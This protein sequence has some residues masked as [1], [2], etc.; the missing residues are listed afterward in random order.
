MKK[1]LHIIFFF[2][3]SISCFSQGLV[4][5]EMSN[6]T[7][8]NR[9]FLEFI[10]DGT[11]CNTVDLRGWIVDD[12]NG[13]FSCGP[14]TAAG[15][16]Q[17]HYRFA[18]LAVW[19][20]VPVGSII[21]IYNEA[22]MDAFIPAADPSD[23]A[24]ADGIYIVPA[25]NA[26]LEFSTTPCANPNIPVGG[27]AC[28]G[29]CTGN[30]G[31]AGVCYTTGSGFATR[32]GLRNTGD[33]GQSRTPAGAYF[34][35][36]AFGTPANNMNGGPDALINPIDGSGLSFFFANTVNNNYRSV[37]NWSSI[38]AAS[39]TPGTSNNANN[40]SWIN[41]L[42]CPLP[43]SLHHF[44]IVCDKNTRSLEWSTSSEINN[45]YFTIERSEDGY[46]FEEIGRVDGSGN[47]NALVS[48]EFVDQ[49]AHYRDYY[50]RLKQTD[51]DGTTKTYNPA[52]SS[53][54][55]TDQTQTYAS[56]MGGDNHSL[57][58]HV[59]SIQSEQAII[60]L[61]DLSGRVLYN[62]SVEL[63]KGHQEIYIPTDGI[64]N[65]IYL[66]RLTG[67]SFDISL[68]YKMIK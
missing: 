39:G 18:N 12:N 55:P 53:C 1:N 10:V 4:L 36:F 51:F 44:S 57:M 30:A 66:I 28:P 13:D 6:G 45:N 40:L 29:P 23:L 37:G 20:A 17:G 33:A 38:A 49:K 16:A 2:S 26:N 42:S 56:M 7:S 63:F 59:Y 67:S 11:P 35:G 52:F 46:S 19:S 25:N 62:Q 50:Y 54:E 60:G 14:C 21:L 15:I 58:L 31:F 34:H 43:V 8:G 3:I 61:T 65:G 32:L 22:D 48:Y 64:S 27:T 9:E 5:N 24:P 41:G 68:K 47:S